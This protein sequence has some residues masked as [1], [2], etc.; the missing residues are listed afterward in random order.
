MTRTVPMTP[1]PALPA[2]TL[3]RLIDEIGRPGFG[4][5]LLAACADLFRADMCSVFVPE[6]ARLRCVL[7]VAADGKFAEQA[8]RAYAERFARSDPTLTRYRLRRLQDSAVVRLNATSILDRDYLRQCFADGAVCER[9]THLYF[10]Q[11]LAGPLLMLNLYRLRENGPFPMQASA[12]LDANGP[13]LSAAA[14]RHDALC[15][16]SA[17]ASGT[18]PDAHAIA[19][20]LREAS[21]GSLTSREA[22]VCAYTVLGHKQAEIAELLGIAITSVATYRRRSYGKLGLGSSAALRDYFNTPTA[23]PLGYR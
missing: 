22:E 7:S 8:S 6:G 21:N 17:G 20:H 19:R 5:S 15:N 14:L 18:M 2:T 16:T 13:V 1:R 9:L 12:A 23:S 11:G 3:A 4:P 10:K